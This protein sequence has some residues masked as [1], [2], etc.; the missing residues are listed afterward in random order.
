MPKQI[1]I[2]DDLKPF[3]NTDDPRAKSIT[4]EMQEEAF[5]ISQIHPYYTTILSLS[6]DG[7]KQNQSL[8]DFVWPLLFTKKVLSI[9]PKEIK[10][11]TNIEESR[12]LIPEEKCWN[13]NYNYETKLHSY[14]PQIHER[15]AD[16]KIKFN[17][18]WLRPLFSQS[19]LSC[20]R[21]NFY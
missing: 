5:K 8:L 21:G 19:K 14:L 15:L 11:V 18:T 10:I 6:P 12:I 3:R 9:L 16:Y 2:D 20:H 7:I 4:K 17:K 13:E 1:K